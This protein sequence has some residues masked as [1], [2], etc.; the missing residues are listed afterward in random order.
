MPVLSVLIGAVVAFGARSTV[1]RL[2]RLKFTRDLKRLDAGDVSALLSAYADD[3]V[4]HFNVGD[5]RFS[6]DWVGRDEIDRFLR[7]FAAAGLRG[8]IK[9][10]A[11]SGPPWAMT[12]WARFDDEA[13]APDGARLYA[14]RSTIVLRTRWGKVVEHED[15]WVD[16]AP[17]VEL[18]H[19]LEARGIARIPKSG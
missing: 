16:T 12:L 14:N 19:A 9:S 7:N 3:A 1:G 2:L 4:L 17:I 8:E 18:E 5:H 11:M 15:F 6:G 10:M 13:R